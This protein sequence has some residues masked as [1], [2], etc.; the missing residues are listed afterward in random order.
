MELYTA[1]DVNVLI[2]KL[3]SVSGQTCR[4]FPGLTTETDTC[5]GKDDRA[6]VNKLMNMMGDFDTV[7]YKVP[8][9]PCDNP[10]PFPENLPDFRARR[11]SVVPTARIK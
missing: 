7:E 5:L 6:C 10:L 3:I 8:V 11:R 2:L 9:L 4:C 1:L